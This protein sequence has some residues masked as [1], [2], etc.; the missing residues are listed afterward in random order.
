[1]IVGSFEDS[2]NSVATITRSEIES[3]PNICYLGKQKDVR[4]F[5]CMS[6][7]FV[8]PSYREGFGMVLMEAGAL[9][10]PCIT[11]DISGCNEIIQDGVNGR[12]IPSRNE[13]AL[14]DAMKWFYEHRD[15]E[16][17]EMARCARHMIIERYE[18]QKVW[19]A[20]LEEYRSLEK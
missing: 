11:T 15:D 18:Q 3:N 8:L 20:F 13:G 9:E 6:D 19:K 17:K 10:V 1:M 5:M 12:I 7:V 16:V 14:Y 2:G 4:P